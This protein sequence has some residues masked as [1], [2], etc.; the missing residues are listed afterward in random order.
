MIRDEDEAIARVIRMAKEGVVRSVDGTDVEIKADS[1]CVHG[2]GESALL[3]VQKIRAALKEAG[4]E[5][6]PIREVLG[7]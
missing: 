4:V 6:A 2:D 7:L 3:F 1:V 5:V